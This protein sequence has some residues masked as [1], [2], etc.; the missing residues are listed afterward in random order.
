MCCCAGA[1]TIRCSWAKPAWA[2]PRSPRDWRSRSTKASV[3][4]ALK[5]VE[6]Y[7]LDMGALLAGTRFRGDFEQRLK[8]VIKAASRATRR[9]CCSSTRSTPSSAPARPRARTMD[10]SNLLKPALASGE[11]RCIGSTTYQEYKRSFD[12]DKALARRFQRIDVHEPTRGRGGAD[13]QRAQELLRK[14][15][16]RAL[17][18][19]GDSRCGRAVGA[20]YQRPLPARQ[21]DRRHGR[22]RRRGAS[23]RR[24]GARP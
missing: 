24:E 16:Q 4:E 12:R 8:A 18:R 1:R 13:S 19:G 14:A 10:A 11:L 22:G 21:G 3:P 23:A 2:R 20:L 6:I 5:G 9:W 7:A 17:H 15:S